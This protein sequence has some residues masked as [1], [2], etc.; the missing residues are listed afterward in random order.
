[1]NNNNKQNKTHSHVLHDN[2]WQFIAR[3]VGTRSIASAGQFIDRPAIHCPSVGTRFIASA[4]RYGT[5]VL[6]DG[7][8][9]E[10][11]SFGYTQGQTGEVV[12]S[13]G[14]VGYPE[15]FTDASFA[16]QILVLT[17]PLTGNYG[18]PKKSLWEDDHIHIAGLVVS[19]YVDT[20]FHA[21][22]TMTLGAW[23]RQERVP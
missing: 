23:L 10:G 1:M 6:E 18:V 14:M 15:A 9:F 17:Y 16:G 7:T 4:E 11:K 21:Q 19:S 8:R 22:S 12:F 5:L 20:P 13:T 3:N 2:D